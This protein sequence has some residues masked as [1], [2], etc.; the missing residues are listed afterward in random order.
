MGQLE[1]YG[2]YVLC[3]VIFLILGV[4]IWGEDAQGA[5]QVQGASNGQGVPQ[6]GAA[7]PGVVPMLA[8]ADR[9]GR[10][11]DF[12][13]G[14]QADEASYLDTLLQPV[15]RPKAKPRRERRSEPKPGERPRNDDQKQAP[16]V[17]KDPPAPPQVVATRKYTVRDGDTISEISSR[18]LGS[19]RYVAAIMRLNPD[20]EPRKIKKGDVLVLPGKAKADE[21]RAAP[22][23]R[24]GAY[25]RYV[26]R[27]GDSFARIAR[28][29]LGAEKRSKEIRRLNPRVDPRRLIPGKTLKLPLK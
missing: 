16:V 15:P 1:K 14:S 27:K 5:G 12:R 23:E 21:S 3:L 22:M 26:I 9:G 28:L 2:L 29:E 7:Q 20:I 13:R 10:R 8:N 6:S 25:R 17:R 19:T 24:A 18:E 4:T 11:V